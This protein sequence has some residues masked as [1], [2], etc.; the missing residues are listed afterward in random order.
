MFGDAGEADVAAGDTAP[1]MAPYADHRHADPASPRPRPLKI[2]IYLPDL[3]GGGAERLHVQLAAVFH[4][5]GHDA[6]FLLDRRSGELL[7]SVPGGCV[8]DVLGAERQ[9]SALPKLVQYLRAARP[10]VL[11]ANM[12]HM[13]VIAVLAR[14]IA[15][16]PTRIVVTQ[17]NAFSEQIKRTSWQW[18]ALPALYRIALPRADAI[19][20]V[21]EGVAD[22]LA[23]GIG[24]ARDR[25]T[26]IHN[27]VVADDFDAR[28]DGV[29]DHPWF[30]SGAPIVTAMGRFVPQKDFATLI[31]G[32][33]KVA[34]ASDARLVILGEGP[35]RGEL[36]ALVAKLSLT[37]RVS[38]PGF[39]A[40]PLPFLKRS[41]LFVLSS[42]F[43]GFGN[44]L[45]EALACGTPAI[46]TDCP[47]GPAEILDRGRYGA[48]VPVGDADRL[49]DAIAAALTATAD[50][51][52]LRGR[53]RHFS[54]RR[55]AAAYEAL[56][57]S[58]TEPKSAARQASRA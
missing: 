27:G 21:S 49:G 2:A 4:E 6:R 38:L 51:A 30:A 36:E 25:I 19:I 3:S 46:S 13:N 1:G 45:A 57:A 7:G 12:E 29:A 58:L 10:D 17:H 43:E 42:R 39:V 40:N 34:D 53:G 28:A 20:A 55:C 47:H 56:M 41:R 48:L 9:L 5:H 23:A 33:R 54:V 35:L 52:A 18:R 15:R 11:I 44:V 16:V 50:Q 32:F 31:E 24:I 8:I 22:D 37:D 14:A 26:V